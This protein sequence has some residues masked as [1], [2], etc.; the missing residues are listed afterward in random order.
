VVPI[1]IA[2]GYEAPEGLLDAEN[3][4]HPRA[5]SKTSRRC[6]GRRRPTSPSP[7]EFLCGTENLERTL[8]P[9]TTNFPAEE[10]NAAIVAADAENGVHY[11]ILAGTG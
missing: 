3:N 4:L 11:V 1:G 6:A 5:A 8:D 10:Q 2:V 7:P 9:T